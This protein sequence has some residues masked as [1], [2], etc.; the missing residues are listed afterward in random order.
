ME[1]AL[2]QIIDKLNSMDNKINSMDNKISSMD[3]KIGSM[4][5]KINWHLESIEFKL[6][7]VH[8]QTAELTEFRTET[9]ENIE[10]V[11]KDVKFIKHKLH[12][13]EED[14]FDIKDY[15]KIVK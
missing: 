3:N 1:E 4:D 12:K 2:K 10:I 15:L 8:D 6:D 9:K 7:S 5:K 13:T 11:S 14:V